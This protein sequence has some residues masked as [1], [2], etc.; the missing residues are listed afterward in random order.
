[1]RHLK[2]KKF[3]DRRRKTK[4]PSISRRFFHVRI[5]R[6]MKHCT[7]EYFVSYCVWL[8]GRCALRDKKK[9]CV[10]FGEKAWGGGGITQFPPERSKQPFKKKNG[11]IT[12]KVPNGHV[13]PIFVANVW[14]LQGQTRLFFAFKNSNIKKMAAYRGEQVITNHRR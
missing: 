4:T 11:F 10:L 2:K 3:G 12:Q 5:S 13:W 7:S 8:S 9:V 6:H 1:M 14:S